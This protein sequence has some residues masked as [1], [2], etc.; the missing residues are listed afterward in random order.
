[1]SDLSRVLRDGWRSYREA[2][3]GKEG[4]DA[5]PTAGVSEP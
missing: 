1:M 5:L 4:G 2:W 3:L